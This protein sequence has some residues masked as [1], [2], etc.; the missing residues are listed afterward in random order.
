VVSPSYASSPHLPPSTLTLLSST[1]SL[2]PY[3]RCLTAFASSHD[4]GP[5]RGGGLYM[6]SIRSAV[7]D[8]LKSFRTA[9]AVL[10]GEVVEKV[11]GEGGA[12]E[13]GGLAIIRSRMMR[14]EN[15]IVAVYG[16]CRSVS[17]SSSSSSSSSS[18]PFPPPHG[19][20]LLT[21]LHTLLLLTSDPLTHTALTSLLDAGRTVMY[22]RLPHFPSPCPGSR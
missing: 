18:S 1:V 20:S 2:G 16:W 5:G 7:G 21:S 3:I 6:R 15:W 8:L 12:G 4:H 14:E 13:D 10:E 17:P 19:C 9:V 22:N 11:R